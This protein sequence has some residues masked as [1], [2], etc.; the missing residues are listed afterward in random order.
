MY[1]VSILMA[2][3]FKKITFNSIMK[4]VI[5]TYKE[6]NSTSKKLAEALDCERH[7][8]GTDY[9]W[10]PDHL[11][12]N[13][14]SGHPL[15]VPQEG[16]ILNKYRNVLRSV[17]KEVTFEYLQ[18][19][20]VSIP[21]RTRIKD[22]AKDWIEQ[23]EIVFCRQDLEGCNG[24]GIVVART[25]EEIVPA[26]LYTKYVNND[27]EFR[28]HVFEGEAIFWTEK[29]IASDAGPSPN[30]LIKSGND[31]SMNWVDDI[32]EVVKEQAIKATAALGLDFA[33]IDI[34][35]MESTF[36]NNDGAWVFESNTAPGGFGRV[37]L[38][39]YVE[40]IKHACN[41]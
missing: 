7:W 4:P 19:A 36:G 25:K 9:E 14:G 2:V 12:V 16:K 17:N 39:K 33:A 5:I 23:G 6:S 31:W 28:V 29:G 30:P 10:E 8:P 32:P 34:G 3:S 26:Q 38:R 41:T 27:R 15:G 22:I 20:G 24:S 35:Y 13:W 18:A 1:F 37:T 11:V 40:A 21:A